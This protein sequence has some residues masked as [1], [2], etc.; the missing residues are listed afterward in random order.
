MEGSF[1][2]TWAFA[3]I[4][5]FFFPLAAQ[6]E[7][8]PLQAREGANPEAA[9]SQF[10]P[11]DLSGVWAQTGNE[12]TIGPD[13]PGLTPEGEARF[14]ANIPTRSREPG[15]RPPAE[16]GLSNDPTFMCN[17]RGFP[18]ILYDTNVA[19]FEF[20]QLDDRLLQLLQRER[21]L[22]ELWTDGREL[23]SG[24]SLDNIGPSW[25]GHSVGAWEADEFVVN[26]VGLDDRAWL[27]FFG[28]P[29]SPE[30]RVEERYRRVGTDTIELRLTLD[31][32]E[33]YTAPW[34]SDTKTFRRVPPDEITFFGWYGLFSG[35]TDLMCAP[36]NTD[37]APASWPGAT[38]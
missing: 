9:Q 10:D 35:V 13:A 16:P 29:K 17:P 30:A 20:I 14:N 37:R 7:A 33:F 11:R 27:D 26:T 34:V 8:G 22:R 15:I 6:V 24:E 28:N 38:P 19:Q 31:D 36:L 4:L 1:M 32:P 18:R 5:G 12:R 23:P 3:L 21:T 2:C 25:Y